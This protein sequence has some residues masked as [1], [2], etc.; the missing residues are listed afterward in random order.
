MLSLPQN[1]RHCVTCISPAVYAGFSG[2]VTAYA[3]SVTDPTTADNWPLGPD[4]AGLVHR[5]ARPASLRHPLGDVVEQATVTAAFGATCC[6]K[7]V[8]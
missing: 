5:L 8:M 1:L 7:A 2:D 3:V 4:D 6:E